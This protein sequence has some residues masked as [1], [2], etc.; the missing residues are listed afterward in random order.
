MKNWTDFLPKKSHLLAKKGK[1]LTSLVFD[2]MEAE[3]TLKNRTEAFN[4]YDMELQ[5]QALLNNTQEQINE[6]KK[7]CNVWNNKPT[8]ELINPNKKK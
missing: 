5:N 2:L 7:K 3:N 6:A 1:I 8:M 4:T